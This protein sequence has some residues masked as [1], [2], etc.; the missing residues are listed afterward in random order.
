MDL[1]CKLDEEDEM[2][3]TE[4]IVKVENDDNDQKEESDR[5]EEREEPKEEENSDF[6]DE[7]TSFSPIKARAKVDENDLNTIV[8]NTFNDINTAH[9]GMSHPKKAGVVCK[10]IYDILPNFNDINIE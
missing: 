6:F 8:D 4:N 5:T 1:E 2:I 10:K 7:K 9:L 3:I